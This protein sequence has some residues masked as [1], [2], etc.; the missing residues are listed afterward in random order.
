MWLYYV[1]YLS[2]SEAATEGLRREHASRMT[3]ETAKALKLKMELENLEKD[4]KRKV[5]LTR[6]MSLKVQ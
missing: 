3:V 4:F 5:S 2:R 1:S 6:M